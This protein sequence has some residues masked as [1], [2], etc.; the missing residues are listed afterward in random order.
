MSESYFV[1][2]LSSSQ[3]V[4]ETTKVRMRK[5]HVL[6]EERSLGGEDL[7]SSGRL[8]TEAPGQGHVLTLCPV[9]LGGPPQVLWEL[10]VDTPLTPRL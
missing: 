10:G 1:F 6:G 5:S 9:T 3:T 8:L 2:Y 7:G 4:L